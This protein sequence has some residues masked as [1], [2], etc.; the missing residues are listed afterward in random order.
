LSPL[1]RASET[2]ETTPSKAF[3]AFDLASPISVA[4]FATNFSFCHFLSFLRWLNDVKRLL[5]NP[6]RDLSP[7]KS[8]RRLTTKALS[9]LFAG[10]PE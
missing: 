4:I 5:L 7:R 6:L 8:V 1:A 2:A 10:K 3:S 9:A